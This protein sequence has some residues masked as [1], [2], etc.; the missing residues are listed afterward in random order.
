MFLCL[1]PPLFPGRMEEIHI[2]VL[3][4]RRDQIYDEQIIRVEK[5]SHTAELLAKSIVLIY[6]LGF[7]TQ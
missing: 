7:R 6:N 1:W 5:E 4:Y 3:P 2:Q